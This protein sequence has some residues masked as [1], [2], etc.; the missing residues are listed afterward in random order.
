MGGIKVY[1]SDEVE[2]KFREMAMRLYGYGRG[3]LS[4]ASEK[5]FTAWLSQLSGILEEVEAVEDPVEA[6]HGMLSHVKKTGVELQHELRRI[7][8]RKVEGKRAAGFKCIPRG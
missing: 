4:I 1:V 5:A 2:K 7:R 8:A 3:S 6:I